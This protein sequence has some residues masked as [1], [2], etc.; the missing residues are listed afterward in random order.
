MDTLVVEAEADAEVVAAD[1]TLAFSITNA[2]STIAHRTCSPFMATTSAHSASSAT[3][4][5]NTLVLRARMAMW[6]SKSTGDLVTTAFTPAG[7]SSRPPSFSV[8]HTIGAD[9]KSSP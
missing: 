1:E 5:S 2:S 6:L 9:E 3:L 7:M 4:A 8:K